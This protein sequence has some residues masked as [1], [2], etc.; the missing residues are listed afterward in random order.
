MSQMP[1]PRYV[2]GLAPESHWGWKPTCAAKYALASAR[3]GHLDTHLQ[4]LH[5]HISYDAARHE[6]HTRAAGHG[7]WPWITLTLA[8]VQVRTLELTGAAW[9]Y[10]LSLAL[11]RH[12]GPRRSVDKPCCMPDVPTPAMHAWAR[13]AAP[14]PGSKQACMQ[15]AT[16]PEGVIADAPAARSC[17]WTRLAARRSTGTA[18]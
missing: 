13:R 18:A 9:S 3:P 17:R 6:P 8:T 12:A 1:G 10:P 15:G 14:R 4:R 11:C 7:S 16:Q 2:A 5:M